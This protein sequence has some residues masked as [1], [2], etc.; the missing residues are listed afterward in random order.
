M[1]NLDSQSVINHIIKLENEVREARLSLTPI[2]S[3]A[4]IQPITWRRWKSGESSPRIENLHSV[5][6][7]IERAIANRE[8]A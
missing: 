4:G 1:N 5:T 6:V 8:A 3:D 2:L 7:A